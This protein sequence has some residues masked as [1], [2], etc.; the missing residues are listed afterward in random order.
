MA[1]KMTCGPCGEVITATDE[2]E[3]VEKVIPHARN[4]HGVTLSRE[5][6]LSY[7]ESA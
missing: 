7:A 5:D 2:D 6:V 1:V 4:D 3:L